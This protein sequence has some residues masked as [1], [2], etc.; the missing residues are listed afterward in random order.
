MSNIMLSQ[1]YACA[2]SQTNDLVYI[3]DKDGHLIDCNLSLLRFLGLNDTKGIPP[4]SIYE[5][6]RNQGLWTPE[7]L[8]YFKQS[9]SEVLVTG[10]K[11]SEQQ[12][13]I[14]NSGSVCYFEFSR[15]P[16]IDASGTNLGLIVTIRDLSDQKKLEEQV[17]R[18]KAQA[19][20]NNVTNTGTLFSEN[21]QKTGKT[22]IL[23]V[24]D[25]V[26]S[27]KAEKKIL[28]A[29]NCLVDVVATP[30]EA[31]ELFKPGKYDLVLMDLNLEESDGF[32]LTTLLRKK[33]QASKF[34]VPIIALTGLDPTDVRFDCEDSEMDGIIRK[35]LTVNQA[36]QLI[37]RYIKNSDSDVKGLMPFK[38]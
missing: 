10:K 30:R 21:A 2:F 14:N 6:M 13:I 36:T 1:I 29:C 18:A 35:P 9:D 22:K 7:Q 34:R 4:D 28:M 15:S 31:D 17:K 37:R 24:E 33:E 32:H 19:T 38:Q 25:N 11:I 27:Q 16:F 12:A 5:L 8:K 26:L 20:Y 3:L 23:L